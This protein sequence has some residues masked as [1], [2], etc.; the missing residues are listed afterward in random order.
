MIHLKKTLKMVN[1]F[2][3]WMK[4]NQNEKKK[5]KNIKNFLLVPNTKEEWKK[6]KNY[7]KN[8]DNNY[9]NYK[10]MIIILHIE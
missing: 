8:N 4:K 7:K 9:K 10:Q 3:D 6:I 2:L 1:N 5:I